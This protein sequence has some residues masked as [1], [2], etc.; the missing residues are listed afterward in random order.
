MASMDTGQQ[1]LPGMKNMPIF[2]SIFMF[3]FLNNYPSG[4]NYYYFLSTLFTI[5]HTYLM[6]QFINEDKIL[7]QLEENKK[8]P[9]KKASGFMA[10]LAEAQKEQ[11]RKAREQAR[12]NAK[13]NYRN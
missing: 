8:K 13:R 12:T 3:F 9:K 4:L 5:V 7:A 11:E 6:K 1:T 10:R 2:M